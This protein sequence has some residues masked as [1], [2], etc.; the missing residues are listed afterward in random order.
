MSGGVLQDSTLHFLLTDANSISG[1]S[2]SHSTLKC[3]RCLH[4]PPFFTG[5]LA[6]RGVV[7]WSSRPGGSHH[8]RKNHL[9]SGSISARLWHIFIYVAIAAYG[10]AAW[11]KPATD[12]LS[13]WGSSSSTT[14]QALV[15][16]FKLTASSSFCRWRRWNPGFTLNCR[17]CWVMLSHQCGSFDVWRATL[18]IPP[19]H[20]FHFYSTKLSD[21][22]QCTCQCVVMFFVRVISSW[23]LIAEIRMIDSWEK[24]WRSSKFGN[25]W[26][27]V[28]FEIFQCSS[29]CCPIF[30][31]PIL[32][33]TPCIPRLPLGNRL[34]ELNRYVFSSL[35]A[36][37]IAEVLPQ[38][39]SKSSSWFVK[40][41]QCFEAR[42]P[43]S[44]YT[45]DQ[46]WC[47]TAAYALWIVGITLIGYEWIWWFQNVPYG[48]KIHWE[49]G[50][51]IQHIQSSWSARQSLLINP[52]SGGQC[53]TMCQQTSPRYGA[54]HLYQDW[55]DKRCHSW[56]KLI[57]LG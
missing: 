1:T 43:L 13:H 11:Q 55:D 41:P 34:Q 48:S 10:E 49:I 26:I 30:A 2:N 16:V 24:I 6:A 15:V 56:L 28:I 9:P 42:E 38:L 47:T 12:V 4:F 54:V 25:Q 37:W 27:W 18:C 20:F 22:L 40:V 31:H 36:L 33:R 3:T 14:A 51:K 32:T 29:I 50:C 19:K 21:V 17:W 45:H 23:Y 52:W 35:R 39:C 53:G 7:H 44:M 57:I 46:L 5:S 8:L